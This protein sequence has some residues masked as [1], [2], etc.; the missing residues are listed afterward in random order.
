MTLL[1]NAAGSPQMSGA[2]PFSDVKSTDS[3]YAAALWASEKGIISGS[4]FAPQTSLTRDEL[5]VSLWKSMDCPEGLQ[6]NQYLDI[7]SHQSDFGKAVAWSHLNGIMGGT[8]KYKFS[9]KK[10]CTKAEVINIL[11]RALR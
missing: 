8:A 2:N 5:V 6:A 9:P 1:W 7:E 11:Y 3:H 10:T 4:T